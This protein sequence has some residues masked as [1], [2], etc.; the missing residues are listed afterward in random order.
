M[1][2]EFDG[3]DSDRVT[4]ASVPSG[5]NGGTAYS[6]STWLWPDTHAN[7]RFL[8][9]GNVGANYFQAFF[10]GTNLRT[11]WDAGINAILDV[12]AATYI[13]TGAWHHYGA[14]WDGSNLYI[15][16]DGVQRASGSLTGSLKTFTTFYVGNSVGS[17]SSLDGKIADF[18]LW[19]TDIGAAWMSALGSGRASVVA[20][21]LPTALWYP[22]L[23]GSASPDWSGHGN[24][25]TITGATLAAHPP[26]A[27]FRR[28][29]WAVPAAGGAFSLTAASGS[30]ALSGQPVS[31]TQAHVVPANQGSYVLSGQDIGLEYGHTVIAAQGSYALSGQDVA[32]PR[33]YAVGAAQGSY[34]LNGQAVTP[35]WGHRLD[36]GQGSYALSGQDTSFPLGFAVTAEPGAYVLSGQAIALL[37]DR[38]VAAAQGAYAL[39]GQDVNLITVGQFLLTAAAGAYVLSGQDVSLLFGHLIQ[40]AQGTY[41]LTGQAINLLQGYQPA[42][43][44]GSYA[45]TGQAVGFTRTYVIINEHGSYVLTGREVSLL[46]SGAPVGGEDYIISLRRRRR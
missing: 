35:A 31:L 8:Y 25:G 20:I 10:D 36:A 28:R 17:V 43:E 26:I 38:V 2:L 7:N 30:Y 32:F 6:V 18:A 16:I 39:S 27:L 22:L 11:R 41:T 12:T 24:N 23:Y 5:L 3:G 4:P 13:G 33:G 15:Y 46:W 29:V 14:R 9:Q 21:P 37:F 34:A 40:A 45:L 42:L 44:Q 19:A 1:S